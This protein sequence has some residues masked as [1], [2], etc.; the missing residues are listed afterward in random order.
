MRRAEKDPGPTPRRRAFAPRTF[1]AGI[2]GR[3]WL[4]VF[5][6][7]SLFALLASGASAAWWVTTDGTRLETRG[8]WTVRGAQVV[9]QL[10]NGTWVSLRK[11]DLD[12]EASAA[13][14]RQLEAGATK[15]G[16]PVRRRPP[17]LVITDADVP[18][19][20]IPRADG[21]DTSSR[22]AAEAVITD[23]APR[24]PQQAGASPRA[25]SSGAAS[26]R[27]AAA[28]A[29][30]AE[31]VVV[32]G[33]QELD[34]PRFRGLVFGGELTNTGTVL[35]GDL[36]LSARLL[37]GEGKVL[38]E[39]S[40]VLAATLLMP[41]ARTRFEVSFPVALPFADLRFEIRHHALLLAPALAPA[42]AGR[43]GE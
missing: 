2:R 7:G 29:Q 39:S 17:V 28:A 8:P 34:K 35:A 11:Q 14:E 9:A 42:T 23:G 1:T 3:A 15:A 19:P 31:P 24:V 32:T 13:L 36:A 41:G 27:A 20:T 18:R 16:P 37:D 4:L 38:A 21:K 30:A 26:L 12:W 10:A 5:A 6:L 40:G 22:D 33:W 43:G 25:A